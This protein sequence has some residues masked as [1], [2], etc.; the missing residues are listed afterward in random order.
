MKTKCLL[1]GHKISDST[2]SG[3]QICERCGMH[4][5]YHARPTI[6]EDLPLVSKYSFHSD[7]I[8]FKPFLWLRWKVYWAKYDFGR[9]WHWN[10]YHRLYIPL[11][12][13]LGLPFD[14]MPF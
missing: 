14:D 12:K 4:E 8:L 1:F 3:Y 11:A 2:D 13:R 10:I 9:W 7:G 5:Y 6:G